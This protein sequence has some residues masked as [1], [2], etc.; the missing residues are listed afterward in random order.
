MLLACGGRGPG[1]VA[2][3]P[4]AAARAET[5][6][7]LT[8][9][10][11]ASMDTSVAP[12]DDFYRYA[13]GGWL[14]QRSCPPTR[15]VSRSFTAIADQNEKVLHDLLEAAARE[16]S[17]DPVRGRL[18]AYYGACMDTEA[19]DALGI[20][21]VQPMLDAVQG[22]ED[23]TGLMR[24]VSELHFAGVGGLWSEGVLPDA[25]RPDM[26]VFALYQGGLGL[27]DR[28]VNTPTRRSG[29]WRSVVPTWSTSFGFTV[30]WAMTTPQRG[31]RPTPS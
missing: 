9:E 26:N 22:I 3:D 10:I 16:P 20:A 1:D 12:C 15:R 25:K 31:R 21:P 24:V 19:I 27:P 8:A 13:C 7:R 23:M 29:W 30:C 6:K 11:E 18:G 17:D 4:E 2:A 28:A 14:T 5:T